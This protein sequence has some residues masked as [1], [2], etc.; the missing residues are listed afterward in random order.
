MMVESQVSSRRM[1]PMR[2]F[3]KDDESSPA[4]LVLDAIVREFLAAGKHRRIEMRFDD[5]GALVT[6]DGIRM[7]QPPTMLA[8]KMII[9]VK[10]VIDLD[11]QFYPHEVTGAFAYNFQ[12]L[13][14]IL[15]VQIDDRIKLLA[16]EREQK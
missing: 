8:K 14:V 2:Q 10:A 5:V 1:T 3:L 16:I 6:F 7:F 12:E 13:M 4:I 9:A 11:P 15:R